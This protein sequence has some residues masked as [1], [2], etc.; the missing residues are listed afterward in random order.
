MSRVVLV[1]MFA[2]CAFTPKCCAAATAHAGEAFTASADAVAPTGPDVTAGLI[3][4]AQHVVRWREAAW[5][6]T[7]CQA[8][9]RDF[10]DA[11]QRWGFAPRLLLAMSINESDLRT[12]VARP[13]RGALDLGLMAVRCKL[14]SD[15]RCTN[16][17]VKGMTPAQVM[18]P[19]TNI[20]KGAEILATL[21]GGNLA[22]YNSG[23][24]GDLRYP[25]KVSAILSALGGVEVRVRGVRL[26]TLVRRIVAAVQKERKS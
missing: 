17:P 24:K 11:G 15:G 16:K 25:T 12:K 6:A 23:H 13:D 5:T 8:R 21:H 2:L 3:C 1:L 20:S 22:S 9:A 26:R 10:A 14:G 7:E 4:S 18:R 19:A